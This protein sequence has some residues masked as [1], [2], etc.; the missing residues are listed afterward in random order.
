MSIGI[1]VRRAL[2]GAPRDALDPH[3]FHKLSLI[4]FLAW[5][6]LGADGLSSSAYGPDEAFRA[7]GSHSSLAVFLA[8]ATALTV[9][10]ISYGYS[11]IVEQFPEGGGGYVVASRVFGP[12]A[13]V[14]SG[15][16]LLVDY[17]LTIAISIVS[18][19]D[20]VLSFL[21]TSWLW[22]KMPMVFGV[23]VILTVLNLRGV[24][25]SVSAIAPVFLLFLA[26]HALLLLVV[27][28]ARL[29]DAASTVERV[30]GDLH[31]THTALGTLGLLALLFRAY[32]MGG[33]TYTGIE[34]VSNGMTL[35]R[36]PRVQTAR[37]T[38]AL[39]A[40]SLA[41]T[42]S[43]ILLAYLLVDAHPVEG[44]TMNFVLLD[45]I[46]GGFHPGGIPMGKAF[47]V[48]SLLSEGLLLVVASQAGFID[49]P[50]VMSNMASDSWLPHRFASLSEQLTMKN[51]VLL[52][53]IAATAAVLYTGGDV[54]KL[55]VM[56][57]I[58]V[59]VT[60]SL[61]NIAMI[62]YW[63]QKR[64]RE[65]HWLRHMPAHAIAA[66]LCLSILII[67]VFEKFTEGGWV[68][69]VVTSA[70][71]VFC[72]IVRRHY[73]HVVV[74]IR[75]F[76]GELP[77]PEESPA[78]FG[79]ESVDQVPPCRVPDPKKPVAALFVGRYGALG[80]HALFALLRMFPRHFEDVV[81]IGI[82]CVDTKAMQGRPELDAT[83]QRTQADLERYVRFASALGLRSDFMLGVGPEIGVEAERLAK[84]VRERY[85]QALFV[86]G[87]LTFEEDTL[88]NRLMHNETA[89]GVHRRL[90]HYGL[91][92][93]VLPVRIR[94]NAVESVETALTPAPATLNA[95]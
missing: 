7:L 54:S 84:L 38:M 50:R 94:L 19:A 30:R 36:E 91:P 63:W 21:P 66:L 10:I 27:F 52:M 72:F 70:L 48:I 95:T 1:R 92:M 23:I 45:K 67:T 31:E 3:A 69:L 43:G 76:D 4:A 65:P 22:L 33:G 32:S 86:A 26:T 71:A 20:Q 58:N 53:S 88:W 40:V 85:P 93:I 59:F 62:R 5:I 12:R 42:A 61:S 15:S 6:G 37:R 8:L 81:F 60:F 74:A 51:G 73:D 89:L 2:F 35:M 14:V 87:Q 90:H 17:V 49:G 39:M 75:R 57:S 34:A 82:A 68:T 64:Q 44:K 79:I 13:G 83:R 47:V 29:G 16:A 41:I 28:G 55:V 56:Y 24:K 77:G 18:G 25:E 9:F 78:T 11:R 46:A 80:R